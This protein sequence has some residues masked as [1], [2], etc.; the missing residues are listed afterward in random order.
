MKSW[1][2]LIRL[3]RG[4]GILAGCWLGGEALRSWLGLVIPGGVIGLGILLALLSARTVAV[5]WV[6]E[7]AAKLLQWLPLLLLPAFVFATRDR[8]FLK[9]HGV[10]F[11]SLMAFTLLALW[12]FVGWLAQFLFA[13]FPSLPDEPGPLTDAEQELASRPEAKS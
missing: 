1:V 13:R 7:A 2:A 3:A 9:E 10:L 8:N 11:V 4:F 6:E 5:E 12:G